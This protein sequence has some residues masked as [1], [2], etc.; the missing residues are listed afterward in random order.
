M[1]TNEIRKMYGDSSAE[2]IH[3]AYKEVDVEDTNQYDRGN[4]PLHT[5]CLHADSVAV[6]ILLA[7]GANPNI[8]NDARKVPLHVLAGAVRNNKHF[9]EGEIRKCAEH[10]FDAGARVIY[11]DESNKTPILAA[12]ER[13]CH[14]LL[15]AAVAKGVKLTTT[16]SSGNTALHLVC[17][18]GVRNALECLEYQQKKVDRL[19]TVKLEQSKAKMDNEPNEQIWKTL[20]ESELKGHEDA[21]KELEALQ[22]TVE[23]FYLSA[24][25]LLEGGLDPDEKNNAGR[26]PLDLAVENNAKR[27]GALLRGVE[28]SAEAAT[29]GMTLHQAAEKGDCEAI[30]ACVKAGTDL[31]AICDDEKG[32]NKGRTPLAVACYHFELL[33]VQTLLELGADPNFKDAD[34][35]NALSWWF[36]WY[37]QRFL[38]ATLVKDRIP[39][40]IFKA[41]LDKGYE[42]DGPI[43]DKSNTALTAACRRVW[44]NGELALLLVSELIATHADVNK[45]NGAGQT[46][47]MLINQVKR[48]DSGADLQITLLEAGA[49]VA[50]VDRDGNTPLHYAA[51]NETPSTGCEMAEMLF[52][53]GD[54][55]PDAVNN[56]GK[57]ALEIATENNNEPLV[58]LILMN[59]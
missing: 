4:T 16:D 18:F 7:R 52:E 38:V 46:P 21:H 28:G 32:D 53:F 51:M 24:K 44:E 8:P 47:L 55:K 11:K 2:E 33:A 45:P 26:T 34:G 31:N 15:D 54:P 29:G 3:A 27:I 41:L 40:Q 30:K 1:T 6:G 22:R 59:S 49:D 12:A 25:A 13:G 19:D 23:G 10:L 42:I 17:D 36:E 48:R 37:G 58:K 9:P 43:D 57:S 5:A 56:A 50:A 39:Q 35:R 20:Y 14:E